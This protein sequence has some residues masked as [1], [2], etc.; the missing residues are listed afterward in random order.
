MHE[1]ENIRHRLPV[2]WALIADSKT[3]RIYEIR[4]ANRI[5]SLSSSRKHP[6]FEERPEFELMTVPDGTLTSPSI[7]DYEL[8]H[9]RRGTTVNA[10]NGARNTYEPQGDIREELKR[11]FA[12]A[13]AMKLKQ[14]WQEKSFDQLIMAAP[15]KMIGELREQLPSR[16]HIAAVLPR[17]LMAYDQKALLDHLQD[18]L[19]EAYVA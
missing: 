17:D 6:A 5:I 10:D 14:S 3:A 12:R 2:I 7:E 18:T 9:G 1:N 19:R 13:I 11:Q 4:K 16:I 15:A 8:G